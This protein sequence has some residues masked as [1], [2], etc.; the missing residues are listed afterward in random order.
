MES[1]DCAKARRL[2]TRAL[3]R[4]FAPSDDK[5]ESVRI[6]RGDLG[7]M[8]P[9]I[10]RLF[11]PGG[12][13]PVVAFA[14][15]FSGCSVVMATRQPTLKDLGVLKPGT[16]RDRVVAELGTPVLTEKAPGGKK[17]VFTFVQ[18]YSKG[19]KVSRAMFH[20]VADVFTIGLWEVVG[21]PVEASFNG[22]KITVRVLYDDHDIVTDSTVLSVA[23]P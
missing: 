20:G 1:I 5:L 7:G 3:R 15:L 17:D 14:L 16:E 22:K 4:K 6:L 2:S 18:G 11:R 10:R 8:I 9:H 12:L 21:T 13:F 23:E 19:A